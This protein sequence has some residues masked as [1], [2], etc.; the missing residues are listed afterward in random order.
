MP[1][2]VNC[3]VFGPA[4]QPLALDHTITT[5]VGGVGGCVI[6]RREISMG[7][8]LHTGCKAAAQVDNTRAIL[9][10]YLVELA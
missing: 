9:G 7:S 2:D 1:V 10:S 6:E 5:Q 8:S 3:I 4:I